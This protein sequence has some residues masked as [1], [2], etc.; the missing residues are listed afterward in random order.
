M[1][2]ECWTKDWRAEKRK[3]DKKYWQEQKKA[4]LFL[5]INS[6]YR[7]EAFPN[8]R[9]RSLLLQCD[10]IWKNYDTVSEMIAE[11]KSD[12]VKIAAEKE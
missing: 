9:M 4:E 1:Y 12:A 5:L 2:G 6:D 11:H 8:P 3:L 10:F 7:Y